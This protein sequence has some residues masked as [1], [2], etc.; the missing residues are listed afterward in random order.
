MQGSCANLGSHPCQ[1][2]GKLSGPC[3]ASR[4]ALGNPINLCFVLS[5]FSLETHR[6]LQVNF[7]IVHKSNHLHILRKQHHFSRLLTPFHIS[8][9]SLLRTILI[10]PQKV[11]SAPTASTRAPSTRIPFLKAQFWR[12][13]AN[14]TQ[15][16]SA[17][18]FTKKHS[19][20]AG[21]VTQRGPPVPNN[22]VSAYQA[23]SVKSNHI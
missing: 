15:S 3:I 12:M 21:V 17:A 10:M 9:K 22:Q 5:S 19:S 16:G 7:L 18:Q 20:S 4:R 11:A 2:G 6:K 1:C 13:Q 8:S 14:E 23:T